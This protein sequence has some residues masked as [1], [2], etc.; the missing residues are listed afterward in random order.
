MVII[1]VPSPAEFA[2]IFNNHSGVV[3]ALFTG[4]KDINSGKS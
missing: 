1:Q 4:S 3:L 2:E